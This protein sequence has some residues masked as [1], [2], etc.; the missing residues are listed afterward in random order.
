[1]H[2]ENIDEIFQWF[3]GEALD[4][5]SVHKFVFSTVLSILT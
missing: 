2:H 3:L 5:A 4:A 1:M